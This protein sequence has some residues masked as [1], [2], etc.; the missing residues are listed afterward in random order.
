MADAEA[1]HRQFPPGFAWGA[2]TAAY[3]IEGAVHEDGRGESIW[4]RFSHTKGKTS[5]GG[6]GDTADDHYHRWQEDIAVLRA[7]H[8]DAYRLSIAWPR[9]L[10][11]GQGRQ[12]ERGLA[13]YERLIDALLTA[14]I[15]PW[16]TLYHWDLPQAL[17]D[18]GGWPSRATA[19]A[20]AEYAD[21]V[22]RR[23]G[24]RVHH[25]I[26]LNE[27]W[28]SGHLGYTTGE[29]APGKRDQKQGLA[30]SHT[31]LLAHGLAIPILRRNSP[32]AQVG[33][34]LNFSWPYTATDT[35]ADR[36]AA[37]RWDG[38]FNRWYLDPLY[39]K[40]YPQD[41]LHLYGRAVPKIQT[42]DFATIAAPTDFLGVNYYGPA[43]IKDDRR[44]RPLRIGHA[45]PADAEKTAMGWV[46][47]PRSFHD[48]LLRLCREYP[49]GPLVI[50]E[51]GAAYDDPAPRQ[52][53]VLDPQ[54]L[55]YYA[56]HLAA[57]LDAIHDGADVRGYFAWSLLDNFEWAS[58]YSRRF[59]LVY[60]D[61]ATQRRTIKDS[62]R[63]YSEV[64]ASNA[65][66]SA[67]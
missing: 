18:R 65:L 38:F 17:Q 54:R 1:A 14:G 44:N 50:T 67:P 34:T 64:A 25:W 48:L 53:R 3:Q 2:A 45:E 21:I 35:E 49:T 7:L 33:I 42:G 29:H 51:N 63:W 62:G 5:D 39:G 16:V 10:P 60:V 52:G 31:L 11:L 41:M 40:G 9:I 66:P 32:N 13:F 46:V 43:Y 28:C 56:G 30:A 12:E 61:Y 19:T 22:S 58:G 37:R 47:S 15:T 24:D 23:L 26:T 36:A 57:L 6:T 59:G 20:F 27:P 8:V 55:R 4:D